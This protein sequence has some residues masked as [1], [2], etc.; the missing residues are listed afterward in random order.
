[1]KT[2]MTFRWYAGFGLAILLPAFL[3]CSAFAASKASDPAINNANGNGNGN[4][5]GNSG[6]GTTTTTTTTTTSPNEPFFQ[7]T[8]PA[9]NAM[10]VGFNGNNCSTHGLDYKTDGVTLNW[11]PPVT[12]PATGLSYTD[13]VMG[14]GANAVTYKVEVA[15]S[16]V[17]GQT[18]TNPTGTMY[19]VGTDPTTGQAAW[20]GIVP[21]VALEQI[22]KG[23]I[24]GTSDT[25]AAGLDINGQ[26]NDNQMVGGVSNQEPNRTLAL[27]ALIRSIRDTATKTVDLSTIGT[28]SSNDGSWGTAA[29][30][31]LVY[32]TGKKDANGNIIES[33]GL[34]LA[35]TF[36]GYG[37]LIIEVADP[38]Q[39]SPCSFDMAGQS[40]WTGLVMIVNTY[41][42]TGNK[43]PMAFVGGGQDQHI[44]GGA[45]LY[46]R[47]QKRNANDNTSLIGKELVKLSGNGNIRYSDAAI[48]AAFKMKPSSMQVRSWRKLAENE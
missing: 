26:H 16:V 21:G 10:G 3:A 43:Q 41:N 37:V 30:P 13:V 20:V 27:E 40:T 33:A 45:F 1:M 38:D 14:S 8:F 11:V 29:N 6:G 15:T 2:M 7:N 4:G 34:H 47:N 18:V 42:P 17:N 24:E 48:D 28:V 23:A 12:N 36:S 25:S 44:I 39:A 22:S 46:M 9:A 5:N 32:A 19:K 35:G 31:A